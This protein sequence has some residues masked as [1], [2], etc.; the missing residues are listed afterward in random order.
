MKGKY[1][2]TVIIADPDSGLDV[3]I[4]IYKLDNA[5]MVGIDESYLENTDGPVF[6]PFDYGVELDLD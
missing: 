5:G 6:S 3:H 2:R 4:A 1:I